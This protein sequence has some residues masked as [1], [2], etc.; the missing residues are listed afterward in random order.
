[1]P[2][3]DNQKLKLCYLIKLFSENTDAANGLTM[4]EILDTLESWDIKAER[5]SVYTDIAALNEFGYDII[6]EKDGKNHVYKMVSRDF[7]L[8]EL[9]LLVDAVQSSKFITES[10]SN[11]LIKKIESLTSIHEAKSLHRQVYVANRI[12]TNNESVYYNVDDIQSAITTNSKISFKYFQWN[13]KKEKELRHDGA[14]YVVSPWALTWD[15]ENYYMVAVDDKDN[16]IK[17][18]R[19][20]KMLKIKVLEDT[21]REGKKLFKDADMALYS[22]KVFGMFGGKEEDVTLLCKESMAGVIIDR[23]GT[24]VNI[25]PAKKGYFKARVNVEVSPQFFAWVFSLGDGVEIVS[26]KS[27]INEMKE[28]LETVRNMYK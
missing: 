23:F 19:V 25:I 11:K 4:Q 10:K 20:D 9:K 13:S 24:I 14:T 2:R 1:M 3:S 21:K 16:S 12:K 26:P 22:K 27:V 6:S 7:E 8:P 18:Y 17:H 28:Q 15:D 5:K